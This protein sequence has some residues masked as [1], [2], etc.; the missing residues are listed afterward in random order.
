MHVM[1]RYEF[2]EAYQNL[3]LNNKKKTKPVVL[4]TSN[5]LKDVARM[6][7]FNVEYFL[8]KPFLKNTWSIL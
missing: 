3:Y 8:T 4:S 5:N 1:D 6:K 7:K 2:L